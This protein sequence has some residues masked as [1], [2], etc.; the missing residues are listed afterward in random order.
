LQRRYGGDL[1]EIIERARRARQTIGEFENRDDLLERLR[2]EAQAAS[3]KLE[4][5]AQSLTKARKKAAVA[6]G[7]R[8]IAE[9]GEIALG[10]GRFIVDVRGLER[11]GALGADRVEFLFAANA[12]ETPRAIARVA[13]GGELSRVLLAVVVALAQSRNS[14]ET[15]IFDEIDAGIGGAT[16]TAVGARLGELARRGQIVCV[17]H[18]AQIA[19]WADRHYVLDKIERGSETTI[20]VREL[21]GPKEREAEIARMLSGETHDVALRHARALL[22]TAKP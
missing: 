17:T 2:A 21:D 5:L 10:S 22:K 8:V 16:A 14:F 20:A 6:L 15:L 11:I 18:L 9:F 7:K 12:G 13:S 1:A 3:R 4:S 19:T